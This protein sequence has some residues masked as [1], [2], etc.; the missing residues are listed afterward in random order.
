MVDTLILADQNNWEIFQEKKSTKHSIDPKHWINASPNPFKYHTWGSLQVYS[1]ESPGENNWKPALYSS[2]VG[3]SRLEAYLIMIPEQAY[4]T[5]V[6][7]KISLSLENALVGSGKQ[8]SYLK[9]KYF[10]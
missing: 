2:C 9:P 1:K 10:Y 5:W 4:A 6:W 8:Q 3:L 7:H